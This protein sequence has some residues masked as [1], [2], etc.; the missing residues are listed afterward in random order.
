MIEIS[1]LLIELIKL[2]KRINKLFEKKLS[3]PHAIFL[4]SIFLKIFF[5]L[6]QLGSLTKTIPNNCF[7]LSYLKVPHSISKSFSS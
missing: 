6:L 4:R 2:I 5:N 7:Q 3:F 1:L